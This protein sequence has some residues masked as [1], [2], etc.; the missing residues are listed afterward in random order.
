MI[1]ARCKLYFNL[2]GVTDSSG[3]QI[4]L[5]SL[6]FLNLNFVLIRALRSLMEK[7]IKSEKKKMDKGMDKL[8]KADKKQDAKCDKMSKGK[9]K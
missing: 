9:K 8:A 4:I 5:R 6:F 1:T 2:F 7:K 3:K